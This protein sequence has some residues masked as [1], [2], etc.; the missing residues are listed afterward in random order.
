[1]A[2][3][4]LTFVSYYRLDITRKPLRWINTSIVSSSID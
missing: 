4:K 1:M 3:Q 2:P